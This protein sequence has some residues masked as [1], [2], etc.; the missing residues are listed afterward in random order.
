MDEGEDG[1]HRRHGVGVRDVAGLE[2]GE[3]VE[4]RGLG[5]QPQVARDHDGGAEL[6]ERMREGQ[7]RAAE[8]PAAQAGRMTS[9]NVCQRLAPI[10]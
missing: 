8:D 6:A 3:D 7:Q 5:P 9:Q 2:L 1:Q 4:R 10:V